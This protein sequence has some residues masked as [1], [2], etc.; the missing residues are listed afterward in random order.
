MSI[1]V[2]RPLA[3]GMLD[4]RRENGNVTPAWQSAAG[5]EDLQKYALQNLHKIFCVFKVSCS[6]NI[7]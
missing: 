6:S 1:P 7:F 4:V 3:A 2:Y 5:K